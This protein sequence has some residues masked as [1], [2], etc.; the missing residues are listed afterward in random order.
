MRSTSSTF[1]PTGPRAP[2]CRAAG[3]AMTSGGRASSLSRGGGRGA[4]G[5]RPP[6]RWLVVPS[7]SPDEAQAKRDRRTG[8]LP[9]IGARVGRTGRPRR[10]ATRRD[11]LSQTGARR[12]PVV[13]GRWDGRGSWMRRG[14]GRL[15]PAAIAL[16]A[17]A[18]CS[19]RPARR[20][21]LDEQ[22]DD[23][24]DRSVNVE[25]RRTATVPAVTPSS[26]SAE[27]KRIGGPATA[28]PR[29]STRVRSGRW[30]AL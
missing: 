22:L 26:A 11:G 1:S 15:A 17:V 30:I 21:A 12:R 9:M 16:V 10:G 2:R 4:H 8:C 7:P 24:D 29:Q 27:P 5:R 25:L 18:G 14:V 19:G 3:S 28:R 13:P 23:S 20:P 6:S